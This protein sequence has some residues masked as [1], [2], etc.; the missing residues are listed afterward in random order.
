MMKKRN[1]DKSKKKKKTKQES[2]NSFASY[3]A[4][5]ESPQTPRLRPSLTFLTLFFMID[6]TANTCSPIADSS[7]RFQ[8]RFPGWREITQR[9]G[10]CSLKLNVVRAERRCSAALL[11]SSSAPL[12]RLVFSFSFKSFFFLFFFHPSISSY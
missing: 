3:S 11:R 7:I 12:R 1:S 4:A 9:R 8:W 2:L 5:R 6:S 10:F